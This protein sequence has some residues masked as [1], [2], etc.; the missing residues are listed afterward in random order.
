MCSY[1]PR[2]GGGTCV[3]ARPGFTVVPRRLMSD[4]S[5]NNPISVG[6]LGLGVVGGGVAAALLERPEAIAAQT[7]RPVNLKKVLVATL[8][9]RDPSRQ[10]DVQL[11][12]G[13]IT[14]NPEDVLADPDISLVVEVIGGENPAASTCRTP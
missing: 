2:R 13:L 5:H 14:T 4:L 3:G 11:P 6:L 9:V 1:L 8:L 10:R 7:G 12:D